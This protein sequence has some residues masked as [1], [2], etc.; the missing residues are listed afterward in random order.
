MEILHVHIIYYASFIVVLVNVIHI[1]FPS[2]F[3]FL[4]KFLYYISVMIHDKFICLA[5][6]F[7]MTFSSKLSRPQ[8]TLQEANQCSHRL[9]QPN[10]QIYKESFHVVPSP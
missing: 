8:K 6:S 9:L 10:Q 4:F 7:P 1:L 2:C 5:F 3:S